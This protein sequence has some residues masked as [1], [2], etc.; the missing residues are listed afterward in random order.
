MNGHRENFES[1]LVTNPMDVET[2]YGEQDLAATSLFSGGFINFG[3]W[4]GLR[5]GSKI[6][7][8][9]RALSSQR[10]YEKIFDLLAVNKEDTVLEIGCGLGNGCI[11]LNKTCA[12][13]YIIGI[14]ASKAQIRRANEYHK[15]SLLGSED[16]IKFGVSK[17]ENLQIAE[18]S[19][20]KAFSLEAL[21]HFS[22]PDRFLKSL[23]KI[24]KTNGKLVIS[25][26]FFRSDP[27]ISFFDS[28]PNFSNGVDKVVKL[29]TFC[30]KLE[31]Y[32]FKNIRTRSIGKHV[33]SG[34]DRWVSQTEYK[35]TW[36]RYWIQAYQQG[37]LDYYI[38][39]AEK[40]ES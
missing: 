22:S 20:T 35:A 2:L 30:S 40:T 28:F 18:N 15:A 31:K 14:D 17:A 6:S 5:I 4:K 11:L 12:P 27:P 1:T 3:Y 36:D 16:T 29:Q 32:G 39:E 34:F 24:L 13:S 10:L 7:K 26:F 19:I 38:I 33:W 9:T 21:Q 23:F 8:K 25:T 37:L